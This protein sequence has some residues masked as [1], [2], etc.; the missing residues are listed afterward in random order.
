MRS[1]IAKRSLSIKDADGSPRFTIELM[2]CP[3]FCSIAPTARLPQLP[4][5]SATTS[6]IA[7]PMP[8]LITESWSPIREREDRIETESEL[9][10]QEG[11]PPQHRREVPKT[12]I[13]VTS[14]NRSSP[15]ESQRLDPSPLRSSTGKEEICQLGM[16][17]FRLTNFQMIE[18]FCQGLFNSS[19][20]Y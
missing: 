17:F 20:V 4:E 15:E 3:N 10:P 12:A 13:T 5:S 8:P 1:E 7:R 14:K 18:D 6:E 16:E 11:G 2:P 9:R 19:T